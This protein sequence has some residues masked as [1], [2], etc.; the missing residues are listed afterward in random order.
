MNTLPRRYAASLEVLGIFLVGGLV[1]SQLI[2]LSGIP[3]KNPL[4]ALTTHMT[5]PELVTAARQLLI[6]LVFNTPVI[7]CSSFQSVGGIG[8]VVLPHTG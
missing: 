6:L 7:F 8:A 5:G 3:V 4:A 1:M 2:R